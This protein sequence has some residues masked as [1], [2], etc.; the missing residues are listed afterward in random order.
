MKAA[1]IAAT[2]RERSM[3]EFEGS[4]EQ[5]RLAV[6]KIVQAIVPEAKCEVWDFENRIRCGTVDSRGNVQEFSLVID[7][8]EMDII[9][10]HARVLKSRLSSD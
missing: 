1:N 8:L 9:E 3:A 2:M 6:Q 7:D 4:P 5:I 10:A